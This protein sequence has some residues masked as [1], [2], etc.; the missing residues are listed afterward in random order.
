MFAD[1]IFI[2]CMLNGRAAAEKLYEVNKDIVF[3]CAGTYGKFSIDDFICAGKIIYNISE[4]GEIEMDD[5]AAAAFAA[6]RDNKNK[7]LDFVSMASHY[8]YLISIG[9]QYDI[10]HC[11][12]EDLLNI[13]PEYVNGKIIK[14]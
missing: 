4:L 12:T 11:F 9:L 3:V 7:V 5:F 2:G 8:K 14:S 10:K 6:Y 13:V 1:N